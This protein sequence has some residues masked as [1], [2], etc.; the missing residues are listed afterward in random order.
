MNPIQQLHKILPPYRGRWCGK[1][2]FEI[3]GKP[4]DIHIRYG[5][6]YSAPPLS[7]EK[8]MKLVEFFGT[9]KIDVDGYGQSGCETCDFGSDYGHDIRVIGAT[10]NQNICQLWKSADEAAKEKRRMR[11]RF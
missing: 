7:V 8:L 1:G 10:K 11:N 4:E 2:T 3:L 5:W 6:M 9:R